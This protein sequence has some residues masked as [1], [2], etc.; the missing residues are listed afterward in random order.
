MAL[1]EPGNTQDFISSFKGFMD[2]AVAQAPDKEEPVFLRSLRSHF[3][4]DPKDLPAVKEEF[5]KA[6]HP[7]LHLAL[8][9]KLAATPCSSN[10]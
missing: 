2:K 4:T 9:R 7:N 6:D 5:E 3:G 10:Y 8:T 1:Q